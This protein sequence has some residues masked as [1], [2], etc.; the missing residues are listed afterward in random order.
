MKAGSL[1]GSVCGCGRILELFAAFGSSTI[2]AA[3]ISR[4]LLVLL[5]SSQLC[6]SADVGGA[7]FFS[8][9]GVRIFEPRRVTT[10]G[11]LEQI[12][13]HRFC[14]F[15]TLV[16]TQL[17]D[18]NHFHAVLVRRENVF[19]KVVQRMHRLIRVGTTMSSSNKITSQDRSNVADL[20]KNELQLRDLVVPSLVV[21]VVSIPQNTLLAIW[22]WLDF[23]KHVMSVRVNRVKELLIAVQVFWKRTKDCSAAVTQSTINH[24]KFTA[25]LL[26]VTT[27][28]RVKR[29]GHPT[30]SRV[31]RETKQTRGLV[32]MLLQEQR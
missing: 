22:L 4:R 27:A 9:L 23:A 11:W 29:M 28:E 30:N 17:N 24:S 1:A 14:I 5:G 31:V 18:V 25:V 8:L 13:P 16:A 26:Q 20:L 10:H 12:I 21:E 32:R 7:L 19:G 3:V 6:L 2:I 15:R